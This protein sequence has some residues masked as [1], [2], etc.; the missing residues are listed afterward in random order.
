MLREQGGFSFAVEREA[1]APPAHHLGHRQRL[2]NRAAHGLAALP[3]YE[4]LELVLARSLPRGDVKPIAKA[5]IG[6]FGGLAGVFGAAA[7]DLK[8][9]KG[10]GPG[11]ALDLKLVHEATL[12]MGRGEVLKRAV[13]SS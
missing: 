2:R 8:G 5:L 3:D 12:R 11:A 10:V 6:R 13:I 4:V 1:A 9:V 7:E